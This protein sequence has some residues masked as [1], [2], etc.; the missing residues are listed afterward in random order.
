MTYYLTEERLE[1]FAVVGSVLSEEDGAGVGLQLGVAR[2]DAVAG[3]EVA[4]YG[5]DLVLQDFF[6]SEA[7]VYFKH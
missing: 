1:C 3:E 7:L 2:E 4:D 6:K 5:L